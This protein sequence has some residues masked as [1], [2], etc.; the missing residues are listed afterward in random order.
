M[1]IVPSR[2]VRFSSNIVLQH[3]F[4]FRHTPQ[5]RL[6]K[7][8][9]LIWSVLEVVNSSLW[10]KA[11]VLELRSNL[12]TVLSQ[13]FPSPLWEALCVCS[14]SFPE[15]TPT[16]SLSSTCSYITLPKLS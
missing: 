10:V 1:L 16:V 2:L 11:E 7:Q 3:V 13:A 14:S 5:D 15:E 4:S 6:H 12:E 8:T 9:R